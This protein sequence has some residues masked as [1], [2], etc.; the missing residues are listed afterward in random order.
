MLALIGMVVASVSTT[1]VRAQATP[2]SAPTL[3][4]IGN[5][6]I[7]EDAAAQTISLTGIDDGDPALVQAMTITATSSN[8]ALIPNPTITYTSPA[9][10]GSLSFTPIANAN[11][12]AIITVRV[13]DD[14]SNTAPDV[15]FVEQTFTVT[16]NPVDDPPVANNDV[17]TTNEDT[18]A[19]G[20]LV[21]N[22]IDSSVLNYELV[23]N[24][25]LGV[26]TI[27]NPATGAYTYVPN[28]NVNGIDSFTFYSFNNPALNYDGIND[29]AIAPLD[30]TTLTQLTVEMWVRPTSS[31]NKGIFQ[32]AKVSTSPVP[33]IYFFDANGTFQ[34]YVNSSYQLSTPLPRNIW[35]HMAAT[36]DGTTWR[37]YKNGILVGSY[38]GGSLY[39]TEAASLY[40]GQGFHGYWGGQIGEAR[41]WSVAR[42]QAQIAAGMSTSALPSTEPN[43]LTNYR[44][45][46]GTGSI[47]AANRVSGGPVATLTNMDPATA[48]VSYGGGDGN[49][50]NT[51]TITVNV[52][53]INDAPTLGVIANRP[54]INED[55]GLQTVIVSGIT[56]GDPEL[57]QTLTLIAT[58]SNPALIP[59]PTVNYT[60]PGGTGILRYTP[61]A[62]ANGTA[63]ITVRAIDNGSNI[64]P[65][66]N[67]IQRIFTVTVN[68]VNDAPTLTAVGNVT[69]N[70]DA[71]LQTVN[72]AGI[73]DSDPELNQVLSVT[74]TSSNP[75][76]IPNPTV[77]YTSPGAT[78][79][80][81]FTPAANASGSTTITVRVTDDGSNIAPNVNFIQRIFTV[82]VNPVNDA[83]TLNAI[84]NQTI[85]E[86]AA[87][88]TV[89]LAGIDDG[90]PELS[91]VLNVTATSSNPTLIPNPTVTYTS[92]GATGSLSFTPTANANGIA[93]ITVRVTDDGSNTAPDVNFV[94]QTFTITVNPVNDAPTGLGLSN[95]SI[96]EN[97][98]IG[99]LVGTFNPTDIDGGPTYT[100]SLVAGTGDTDNA[101]F[102][103]SGGELH[104]AA[105]FD[106]ETQTSYSIR[107]AVDDGNG[108]IFATSF[109]ISITNVSLAPII[110]SPV[111]LAGQYGQNYSH[112]FVASGDP[113]PTFT[114]TGSLPAG[115]SLSTS[116]IL[117]G[118]P[119]QVGSFPITVTA[120]N[121]ISPA[122]AQTFTLVIA[123]AP[124]IVIADNKARAYGVANPVLTFTTS[125]F[126]NNDTDITALT[127][128]LTTTAI[129][130][131]SIGAYSI[132]QGSLAATNYTISFTNGTL[133]IGTAVLN[134]VAD[135][136][137]R[138]YGTT[139]PPLTYT[140]TGFA[141]GDTASI[142]S[143]ALATTAVPSSN[144]GSY[145]ISQGTLAAPN[146]A[147]NYTGASLQITQV[148]LMAT[149]DNQTRIY[150][151]ANPP[152]TITYSG[153]VNGDTL[154]VLD[155][156]PVAS[157][158]AIPT[159]STGSYPINVSGGSDN[160]YSLSYVAGTLSILPTGQT[161][162]SSAAL[163]SALSQPGPVINLD[164]TCRYLLN[165][166]TGTNGHIVNLYSRSNL[167][168]NG[169]GAIIER[170]SSAGDLGIIALIDN[171][172][173]TIQNLTLIGGR[174]NASSNQLG[175]RG[176]GMLL[177][178]SSNVTLIGIQFYGN[179]ATLG[180]GLSSYAGS[181]NLY[182]SVLADNEALS[183]GAGFYAQ[184][185]A[186]VLNTTITS[187]TPNAKEAL[188]T[189]NALTLTNTILS[190]HAVGIAAAGGTN[191]VSEDYN[192]FSDLGQARKTYNTGTTIT[193]GAASFTSTSINQHFVN[194]ATHDYRLKV[195]S[196]AIDRG[197][198]VSAPLDADG[199]TRPFGNT[200]VDIGAYEFQGDGALIIRKIG[201]HSVDA[202]ATFTYEI[203][204]ANNGTAL[205]NLQIR[206]VLPSGVSFVGGA[207]GGG[208][209]DGTMVRWDVANLAPHQI[210]SLTYQAR[211]SQ[212]VI[213]TDYTVVRQSDGAV[214][215][216][217]QQ[218]ETLV[219]TTQV[220]YLQNSKQHFFEPGAHGF[221]FANWRGAA[222]GAD[223]TTASMYTLYGPTVCA[224]GTSASAQSCV[225]SA[226]AQQHLQNLLTTNANGRMYGM[227]AASLKLFL[228]EP[229]ADGSTTPSDYQPGA[230][231]TFDLLRYADLQQVIGVYQ[232]GRSSTPQNGTS[233]AATNG[234][235]GGLVSFL[236][237]NGFDGPTNNDAYTLSI[238]KRN[239]S[240]ALALLPYALETRDLGIY[241]LYV[242]DPTSPGDQTRIIVI[243]TTTDTWSYT[244]AGQ[245]L[246]G[247]VGDATSR[248][249]FLR[250]LAADTSLP[251]ACGFCGS[252]GAA[253]D[254]MT[255]VMNGTGRLLITNSS[256]Q[257]TG[258]DSVA[259]TYINEIPGASLDVV[260]ADAGLDLPPIIRVP[261]GGRY[262][263]ALFSPPSG[264]NMTQNAATN[265]LVSI[266][267]T[268][269]GMIAG[270]RDLTLDGPSDPAQFT[271][272]YQNRTIAFQPNAFGSSGS[273]LD[274]AITQ[275]D[276]TS[277]RFVLT[278]V[279]LSPGSSV[280][281]GFDPATGKLS[282]SDTDT[283]RTQRYDLAVLRVQP[284]GASQTFQ[285]LDVTGGRGA[286]AEIDFN[287]WNGLDWP[288]TAILPNLVS[289]S[290]V[291]R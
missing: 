102:S 180:G 73:N 166:L 143:G 18:T 270:L 29:Y 158:A 255:Y 101:S 14:G 187:S 115:V 201:P 204:V 77:T 46:D 163:Q 58:S 25:T 50:S 181:T 222:S 91:Q 47:T 99:T 268:A 64:A 210:L 240:G 112:T 94:E 172:N 139:N 263:T 215:A 40:F 124:L 135:G 125:G 133:T 80:L 78:G 136:Q 277:Y 286:G 22:D 111:P 220:L 84:G 242:Y 130:S 6:T 262:T 42:S 49:I 211:T 36:Y 87:A 48:W 12:T 275:A 203:V 90:D 177:Y 202:G 253:S 264:A 110:T 1:T 138:P 5:Q 246:P 218:L 69:I 161:P 284:G 117:N 27:T 4:T 144:V 51:A 137:T 9:T 85:N 149:A 269:P 30:G 62:N 233:S 38:I 185:P 60:N 227:V 179:S 192:L 188:F 70:E 165:D 245:T 129:P 216:S 140:V 194:P 3:D 63:T 23:S 21:A 241:W 182:S 213:N 279:E 230:A 44:F 71:G 155:I 92:P 290:L 148:L 189:W 142:I 32:W 152:L 250:S 41:I 45:A 171:T 57:V 271:V 88:Q 197:T 10:T 127:G 53:P 98:P 184:G 160:N 198:L 214:L 291:V 289:L 75:A 128:T 256:G 258:Y 219:N 212:S 72:L 83:P 200:L 24:G 114:F 104:T 174:A 186:T 126:V 74:A 234:T 122:A 224:S 7:D 35:T 217:G 283:S 281:I 105:V 257:R 121:G 8:P 169:N 157:T 199:R 26:A 252:S 33:F 176:G 261:L 282:L 96:A 93:T 278:G 191:P 280:S 68:P 206:D 79:S 31:G 107:V 238:R 244:S 59:N 239:G 19:N 16:V 43:L 193:G 231:L 285:R 65:N 259:D 20:T 249:I 119:T 81:S 226:T 66:V 168:I 248:S 11:G 228:G 82:T 251:R 95:S 156:L 237:A 235:P 207:T 145:A 67:F 208:T 56:D 141:N 103:I 162:C 146:Y 196:P 274:L 154:N 247:Y 134:V 167:T 183:N 287:S 195:S 243:D 123:P 164:G 153:F 170:T 55:S 37:L 39:Q 106:Y 254:Q 221:N 265:P 159:S 266:T 223:L 173:V 288:P 108:G 229:L 205:N 260:E 273:A 17:L 276:G 61:V 54:P 109:A 147:I 2:N 178:N 34:L 100:Y 113:V 272:D 150:G 86:D 76:L 52:N 118:T 13:T 89:N 267:L 236:L 15:N 232:A 151:L 190:N 132:T 97:E 131:T 209:F 175:G 225:L 28:P 120:D 116:G